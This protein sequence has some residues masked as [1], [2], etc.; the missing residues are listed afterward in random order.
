MQNF[1]L[2]VSICFRFLLYPLHLLLVLHLQRLEDE[3]EDEVEVDLELLL[4]LLRLL[5]HQHPQ[6]LE[7][8]VEH[9]V[10]GDEVP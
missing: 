5:H 10:A 8:E 2:E 1:G 7:D 9:E 6:H 3:V 4:H